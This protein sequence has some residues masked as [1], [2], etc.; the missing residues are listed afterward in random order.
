MDLTC[1]EKVI[2]PDNIASTP[3]HPPQQQRKNRRKPL[4]VF[5][6]LPNP[7]IEPPSTK[8]N[9]E[10]K[11][12]DQIAPALTANQP[13]VLLENNQKPAES[14]FDKKLIVAVSSAQL[15][16]SSNE[17]S[18]LFERPYKITISRMNRPTL[19]PRRYLDSAGVAPAYQT[20]VQKQ[21]KPSPLKNLRRAQT[22][23]VTNARRCSVEMSDPAFT[24]STTSSIMTSPPN[25]DEVI[26]KKEDG[27]CEKEEGDCE[28]EEENKEEDK[29]TKENQNNPV[30]T[31][32]KPKKRKKQAIFDFH[33]TL[34]PIS[35]ANNEI[36]NGDIIWG[37]IMGYGWWPG[38][39]LSDSQSSQP[40]NRRVFC[41]WFGSN[42][43]SIM[44]VG[45]LEIFLPNF[46]KRFD[47]RRNS[48]SYT[49]AVVQAQHCCR[50]KYGVK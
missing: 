31:T 38:R 34:K 8:L 35:R 9:E 43:N 5:K 48:N 2:S 40:E 23:V 26:V 17:S 6:S 46:E 3:F 50:K 18:D 15:S 13:I 41:T 22:A 39:V 27:D 25:D 28:K 24:S 4:H 7:A 1:H 45:E 44:N 49:K 21:I 42:T 12:I 20:L 32:K 10:Y 36:R 37:K 14:K 47:V 33:A 30:P 16:L 11:D 29:T 19:I